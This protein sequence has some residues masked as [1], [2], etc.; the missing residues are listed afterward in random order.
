MRVFDTDGND[1]LD[2]KEFLMAMDIS[3]C[4]TS[5]LNFSPLQNFSPNFPASRVQADLGLQALRCRQRRIHRIDLKLCW[6]TV[7]SKKFRPEG[8]VHHHRDDGRHRR[9]EA[10]RD[11]VRRSREPRASSHRQGEGRVSVLRPGQGQRRLPHQGPVFSNL[12]GRGPTRLGSHWSSVAC[13]NS[14]MP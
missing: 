2:F 13:A 9:S 14:L 10:R 11:P 7:K 5:E 1:Y 4:Q 6:K 8:D 3:N 12:I